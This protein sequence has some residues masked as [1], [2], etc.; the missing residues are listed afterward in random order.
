MNG[1]LLNRMIMD[2]CFRRHNGF[3]SIQWTS[4]NVLN[5]VCRHFTKYMVMKAISRENAQAVLKSFEELV[6]N[7]WGCTIDI[8]TDNGTGFSNKMVTERLETYAM[9]QSNTSVYQVQANLTERDNQ[10][11]EEMIGTF[12]N[13][14][15]R[16]HDIHLIEFAFVINT[17]VLP[18]TKYSPTFLNF[19]RNSTPY[20]LRNY[21]PLLSWG[22]L[23]SKEV[24]LDREKGCD[25]VKVDLVKALL[26]DR[27]S[28]MI[29]T[30]K[31]WRSM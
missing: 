3:F 17:V 15:Q 30:A 20:Y 24:W 9:I 4:E 26:Q 21:L 16:N 27:L 13:S 28:I 2:Y 22:K 8:I 10:T 29:G 18:S 14:D 5:H 25:L 31:R 11:T 6:I 23:M 1:L 12:I 19:G 7:K